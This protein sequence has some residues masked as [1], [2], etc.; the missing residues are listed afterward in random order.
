MER[1]VWPLVQQSACLD[2]INDPVSCEDITPKVALLGHLFRNR[3]DLVRE[4]LM[5]VADNASVLLNQDLLVNAIRR[6][7]QEEYHGHKAY[8]RQLLHKNGL[9]AHFLTSL[10]FLFFNKSK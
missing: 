8:N 3:R 7:W 1:Q 2:A 10:F 5:E 4:A 6:L 9:C